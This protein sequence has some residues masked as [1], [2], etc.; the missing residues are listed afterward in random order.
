MWLKKSGIFI[1]TAL[2]MVSMVGLFLAGILK[3]LRGVKDLLWISDSMTGLGEVLKGIELL[4]LAPL[5]LL[6]FLSMILF[7]LRYY[8]SPAPKPSEQMLEPGMDMIHGVKLALAFL[9]VALLLT[10]L[11]EKA[12]TGQDKSWVGLATE[13]CGVVLGLAYAA[14]I[15]RLN[16]S[17]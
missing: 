9:V 1:G 13:C 2:S 4:F 3:I 11:V 17:H 6:A 14:I 16:G 10:D 7:V 15:H 8:K 12:L 5:T